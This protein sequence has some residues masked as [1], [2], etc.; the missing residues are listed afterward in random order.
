[1]GGLTAERVATENPQGI[2]GAGKKRRGTGS[3][4]Q[5]GGRAVPHLM[6]DRPAA[7]GKNYFVS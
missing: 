6:G 7:P 3:W 2:T 5:G 1:V 4:G